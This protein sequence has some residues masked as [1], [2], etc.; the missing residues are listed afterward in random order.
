MNT[1][2]IV[3]AGLTATLLLVGAAV[4]QA[5]D[6]FFKLDSYLVP[7]NAPV[8]VAVLN[9]TFQESED[10]V[11]PGR[12]DGLDLVAAGQ[13]SGL[14]RSA[15]SAEGD[16]SWLSFRTRDAGTYVIGASTRPREIRLE[17]EDF[18]YYLA[19]EEILDVLVRR[20]EERE[21]DRPARERYSKHVK[22]VFQVGEDRSGGFDVVLGHR[23]E[24]V[25]LENP[26]TL[27][28]GDV[29]PVRVIVDGKPIEGLT[30]IAGGEGEDGQA[31]DA[32]SVRSDREGVARV[33]LHRP[34]R[35]YVKFIHMVEA[36]DPEL[37][38]VSRWATLTFEVR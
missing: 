16:T 6:L 17:A 10:P 35:W 30:V 3:V 31:F 23:A 12:L 33:P 22:A 20:A 4:L 26:Y 8:R 14:P 2:K 9:G 19:H 32:R 29:L 11:A 7:A 13:R 28:P 25:P 36:D 21:L 24:L 5:H 37:E 18:N 34:G 15:W 1:R 38:Y 27:D